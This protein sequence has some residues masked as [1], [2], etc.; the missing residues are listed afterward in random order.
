MLVFCMCV[1]FISGLGALK[2]KNLV[3][4]LANI[5]YLNCAFYV[6]SIIFMQ[7]QTFWINSLFL[8]MF[9]VFAIYALLGILKINLKTERINISI[10]QNLSVKNRPFCLLF[11]I[12]L[13]IA[14]NV[15]PSALFT[16]NLVLLKGVY[17]FDK[18][19]FCAISLYVFAN[20]LFVINSLKIMQTC[21]FVK[22]FKAVPMLTK[23]TTPNYVVPIVVLILLILS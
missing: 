1:I 22:K 18:I 9:V 8:S 20:L 12:L 17:S 10:M 15:F 3:K 6:I 16:N 19:G 13:L 23:R 21:Y 11:S 14:L 4:F 5:T 7:E 2:T